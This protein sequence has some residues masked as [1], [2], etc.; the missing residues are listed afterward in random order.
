MKYLLIIFILLLATPAYADM[1]VPEKEKLAEVKRR[2]RALLPKI[3]DSE[4]HP[5]GIVLNNGHSIHFEIKNNDYLL[6]GEIIKRV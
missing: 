5:D 4:C 1:P 2:I 3:T 6:K